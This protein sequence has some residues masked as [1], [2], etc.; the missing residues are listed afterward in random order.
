MLKTTIDE[1][2]VLIA[3][4]TFNEVSNIPTLI[5]SIRQKHNLA[6]IL[7]VDGG[8]TDGTIEKVKDFQ[9]K[10]EKIELVLQKRK[11]GIASA[12][13]ISF[14]YAVDNKFDFLVTMDADCSHNP[15]EIAHL[16]SATVN[17]DLVLGSRYCVGGNSE[18][19]G[20]RDVISRSAN[21][22]ASLIINRKIHEFTTS[23]RVFRVS[24]FSQL[25]VGTINS[26]G[27][28]FFFKVVS[29]FSRQ[30]VK[31]VE[32][33]IIFRVRAHGSSK[34]PKL[35]IFQSLWQLSK[36]K[37]SRKF[38]SESVAYRHNPCHVCASNFRVRISKKNGSLISCLICGDLSSVN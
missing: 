37:F 29:A 3:L 4:I 28:S 5:D 13:I 25:D 21:F 36:I 34:I 7:V 22:F 35:E 14:K 11:L 12:H 26:N 10:D 2:G 31:I 8:S 16:L 17:H 19:A 6:T 18:V 1:Q 9:K 27:Y 30:R 15:E 20:V 38:L 23:F 33:P 24:I 32:V